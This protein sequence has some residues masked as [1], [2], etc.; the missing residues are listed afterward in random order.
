VGALTGWLLTQ[1]TALQHFNGSPL[2]RIFGPTTLIARGGTVSFNVLTRD[3]QVMD[4]HLV[5]AAAADW[6][7]S[8]RGG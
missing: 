4:Y 5:E 3:G 8:L 6:N 2:I 1:L 7:I